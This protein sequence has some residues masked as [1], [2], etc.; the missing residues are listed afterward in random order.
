MQRNEWG[1]TMQNHHK[2]ARTLGYAITAFSCTL[3]YAAG[4][5]QA[6]A[7]SARR[8]LLW[9]IAADTRVMK[10]LQ[11]RP[12]NEIGAYINPPNLLF[13]QKTTLISQ[14]KLLFPSGKGAVAAGSSRPWEPSG[15]P[16]AELTELLNN[17]ALPSPAFTSL[18][19]NNSTKSHPI[20]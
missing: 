3:E 17:R 8:S 2:F 12:L 1:E 9:P 10:K 13:Q 16:Q 11:T 6:R 4:F 14:T 5:G 7:C 18:L 20:S 15:A 19:T